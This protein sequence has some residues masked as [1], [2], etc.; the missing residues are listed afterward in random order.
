MPTCTTCH[1][2]TI[3]AVESVSSTRGVGVAGALSLA[4]QELLLEPRAR[5]GRGRPEGPS[6]REH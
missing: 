3:A 4:E 2:A 6:A 5:W 1:A